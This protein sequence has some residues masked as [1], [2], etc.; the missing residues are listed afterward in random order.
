MQHKNFNHINSIYGAGKS[1]PEVNGRIID[2]V[3]FH[4][5]SQYLFHVQ[6]TIFVHKIYALGIQII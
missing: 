4:F 1:H 3:L 6:L 5:S 2:F